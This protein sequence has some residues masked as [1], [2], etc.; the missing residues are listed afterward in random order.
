MLILVKIVSVGFLLR[1]KV[2]DAI[3]QTN[4]TENIFSLTDVPVNMTVFRD[5]IHV[6]MF[7]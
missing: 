2:M 4:C 6:H 3:H 5:D 7:I 1:F